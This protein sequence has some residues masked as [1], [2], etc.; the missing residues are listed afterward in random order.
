MRALNSNLIHGNSRQFFLLHRIAGRDG[1]FQ[2]AG[3]FPQIR[4]LRF[5]RLSCLSRVPR[6]VIWEGRDDRLFSTL[7][8][9]RWFHYIWLQNNSPNQEGEARELESQNPVCA[10]NCYQIETTHA[11]CKCHSGAAAKMPFLFSCLDLPIFPLLSIFLKGPRVSHLHNTLKPG[12]I[13]DVK[14]DVTQVS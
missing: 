7:L 4:K 6:L 5:A 13:L 2:I 9:Q 3:F 10:M 1:P 8:T 14:W 12:N 11:P